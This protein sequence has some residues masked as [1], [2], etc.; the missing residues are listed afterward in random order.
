MEVA[1]VP[2]RKEATMSAT[3]ILWGQIIAVFAL[4]LGGVRVATQWIVAAL[5][6]QPEL[7]AA[8]FSLD[9]NPVYPPYAIFW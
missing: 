3:R 2:V 9:G 4:A 1:P 7:G 6:Y 5:G 8:W